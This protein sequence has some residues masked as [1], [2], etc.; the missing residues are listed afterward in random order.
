[1]QILPACY[2]KLIPKPTDWAYLFEFLSKQ[3]NFLGITPSATQKSLTPFFILHFGILMNNFCNQPLLKI[4][5][6]DDDRVNVV[7]NVFNIFI[8]VLR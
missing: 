5:K 2:F 4:M 7:C 6:M 1:M 8:K 3:Y